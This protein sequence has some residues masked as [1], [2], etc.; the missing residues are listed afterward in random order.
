MR[1]S[2]QGDVTFSDRLISVFASLLFSVPTCLILSL[3]ISQNLLALQLDFTV[4][5]KG[6]LVLLLIFSVLAFIFP[7]LFPNVLG[8]VWNIFMKH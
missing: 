1:R 7:K 8:W 6:F 4:G 2:R 5:G 3:K